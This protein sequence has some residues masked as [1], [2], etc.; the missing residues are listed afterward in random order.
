[1]PSFFLTPS[2]NLSNQLGLL[3]ILTSFRVTAWAL[4]LT[5]MSLDR[6]A[7]NSALFFVLASRSKILCVASP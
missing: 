7:R 3:R 6:V 2:L 4:I 1:M 5:Y